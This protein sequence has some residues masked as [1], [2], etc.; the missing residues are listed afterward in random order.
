MRNATFSISIDFQ[1]GKALIT[2]E[3]DYA[4]RAT[5]YLAMQEDLA[6][7]I[8]TAELSEEMSIPYRFLRKIVS[9]LVAAG[10]VLSRRGKGGGLSLAKAPEDV[11]L[12]DV[13]RAVDPD[14]VILNRCLTE[15]ESCDRSVFCGIHAE[16]GRMQKGLDEGLSAVTL[17]AISKRESCSTKR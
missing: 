14:A 12:L 13:I 1:Q 8:S 10:L 16:L 7:S 3:T 11:S 17:A 9:K 4:L 6:A 15:V 5:L 2:R